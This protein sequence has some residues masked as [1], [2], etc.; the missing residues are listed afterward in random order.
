MYNQRLTAANNTISP[1]SCLQNSKKTIWYIM[2]F[3]SWGIQK[4]LHFKQHWEKTAMPL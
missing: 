1:I 2:A 3:M 4:Q